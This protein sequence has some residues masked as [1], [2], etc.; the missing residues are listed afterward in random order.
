MKQPTLMYLA[1]DSESK[2]VVPYDGLLWMVSIRLNNNKP[3]LFENCNGLTVLPNDICNML[4]DNNIVKV[5]QNALHDGVYLRMN[6]KRRNGKPVIIRNIWDTDQCERVIQGVQLP[7]IDRDKTVPPHIERLYK[8]HGSRLDYI[9]VRYGFIPSKKDL[10]TQFIDRPKGIPFSKELK[11]YAIGD[12]ADLNPI[13]ALQEF[14]LK[15]E[16]L[17][18]LAHLEN[19][20]TGKLIEMKVG[21][22]GFDEDIWRNIAI[23]NTIEYKKRVSMLPK[24][25]KNWGSN[26]QVKAY[27]ASIGINV[28]TYDDLPEVYLKSRNRTLAMFMYTKKLA[29]SVSSYGLNW[30][31]GEYK[32]LKGE[33]EEGSGFV[34]PDGR[35]RCG[36]QQQVNTGR[37]SMFDPPLQTMP[38]VEKLTPVE[39]RVERL[40]AEQLG[41]RSIEM[42][43]QHRRGFVPAKGK[44]FVK[45]DFSG[46]EIGIMAAA[47]GE[48][49]WINAMKRGED[50][51]ALTASL[52]YPEWQLVKERGCTFPKKCSCKEH[53]EMRETAKILNF[54]LA[55]GGGEQKFAKSTGL[56]WKQ[57]RLI[58]KRYKQ[59]IPKLTAYLEKNGKVSSNTGIAYSATPFRRRRILNGTEDWQ[60]VNQ[61]KN[62]PIQAAGADMLKLA[63]VSIPDKFF[64]PIVIHD[65]IVLEVPKAMA[66]EAMRMLKQVME[67]AADYCTGIKG[68]V[69]VEPVIAMN[70]MKDAGT[71]GY[72]LYG[73][74]LKQAA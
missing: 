55:Y 4:E 6:C 42:V 50:V 27:F 12:V 61:G 19:K 21:G 5:I 40:I 24:S 32:N 14:V 71:K 60:M 62:T 49:L 9:Q 23:N 68:L 34:D 38:G 16:G 58:I 26:Q 10:R 46:Q 73:D 25:V 47:S 72:N 20:T 41:L 53:K 64:M 17:L 54:M 51:H 39:K 35:I 70:L 29:K 59:V 8:K 3:M 67:K 66:R 57:S 69:K 52:M 31:H 18:D 74:R 33:V 7:P 2:G 11:D 13:R 22:L 56:D 30:L 65:E 1:L 37:M 63:M 36:I 48:E 28:P 45:G 43:P 44:I 15:R